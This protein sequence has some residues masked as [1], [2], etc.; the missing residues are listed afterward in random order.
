[1]VELQFTLIPGFQP[2]KDLRVKASLV[3]VH[4]ENNPLKAGSFPVEEAAVLE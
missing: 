1:M 2:F 4:C 3:D